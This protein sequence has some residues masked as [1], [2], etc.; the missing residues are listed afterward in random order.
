MCLLGVHATP[1]GSPSY[2]GK[3]V[4]IP[5]WFLAEQSANLAHWQGLTH[6]SFLQA[7]VVAQSGSDRHSYCLQRM[8][9]SGSGLKSGRQEQTARWFL[10]EHWALMPHF[11]KT[12][13]STHSRFKQ[14]WVKGHSESLLQP[15]VKNN[16]NI[17]VKITLWKYNIAYYVNNLRSSQI[18]Y[19]SPMNPVR[20]TQIALWL[21][22]RQ[23]AFNPQ[24][25]EK[26]GSWHFSCMHAR[27]AGHS[28][29]DVHSGL[30]AEMKVSYFMQQHAKCSQQ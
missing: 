11:S 15:A 28:G 6:F 5:L 24:T 19:G 18:V 10:A 3:H 14:V 27:W 29:S 25:V 9:G 2:P 20:Q 8:Y 7:S 21:L 13:G 1:Y 17:F 23:S 22:A 16:G 26:Q 12:H 4:Q 30:G